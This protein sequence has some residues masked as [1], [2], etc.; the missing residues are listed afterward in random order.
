MVKVVL[1]KIYKI[2]E[3][4]LEFLIYPLIKE[5]ERGAGD[6]EIHQFIIPPTGLLL[7][8]L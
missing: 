5:E 2:T 6:R 4:L 1:N 8:D 7:R 3:L